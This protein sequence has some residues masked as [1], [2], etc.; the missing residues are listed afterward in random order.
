[1]R[2]LEVTL[3]RCLGESGAFAD[4]CPENLKFLTMYLKCL[5][6]NQCCKV[7]GEVAQ[8]ADLVS[9]KIV[10]SVSPCK[11]FKSRRQRYLGVRGSSVIFAGLSC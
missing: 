2:G 5:Q 9:H 10:S 1:M 3:E 6:A 4:T 11:V 8:E 7:K